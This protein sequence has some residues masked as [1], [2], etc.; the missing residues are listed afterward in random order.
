[1]RGQEIHFAGRGDRFPYGTGTAILFPEEKILAGM[2]DG[3]AFTG[4][5][6]K[7]G[8]IRVGAVYNEYSY[9]VVSEVEVPQEFYEHTLRIIKGK[10]YIERFII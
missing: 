6:L 10:Q 7:N 8:K 2:S 9:E 4:F 5:L 1:M 3:V